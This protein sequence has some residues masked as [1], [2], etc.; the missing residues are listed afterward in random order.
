[1]VKIAETQIK[2]LLRYWNAPVSEHWLA[3]FN[4]VSHPQDPVGKPGRMLIEAIN[5]AE[6]RCQEKLFAHKGFSLVAYKKF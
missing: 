6:I 4:K 3:V 5:N 1:M 2:A